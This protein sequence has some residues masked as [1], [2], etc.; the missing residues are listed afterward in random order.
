MNTELNNVVYK[1][2]LSIRKRNQVTK[3]KR[4]QR[5]MN[6]PLPPQ[7]RF[8]KEPEPD[9]RY[10]PDTPIKFK[11]MSRTVLLL[12]QIYIQTFFA[13]RYEEIPR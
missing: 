5:G 13:D 6:Q 3:D 1:N 11:F 2:I 12:P 4:F 8:L 9:I 7:P 10:D